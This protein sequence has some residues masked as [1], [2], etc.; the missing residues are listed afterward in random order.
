D[1]KPTDGML[2]GRPK[3]VATGSAP[4]VPPTLP[5]FHRATPL[6]AK[7]DAVRVPQSEEDRTKIDT[8]MS[9]G[10]LG[11]PN[12]AA[13]DWD[14]AVR[15]W[16]RSGTQSSS[17]WLQPE[18]HEANAGVLGSSAPRF[19]G[20][21]EMSVEPVTSAASLSEIVGTVETDYEESVHERSRPPSED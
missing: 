15:D 9:F 18:T 14:A 12:L 17:S 11:A 5:A 8:D 19:S 13:R 7:S 6:P 16:D 2:R 20:P 4:S 3:L 21:D 1:R 10:S